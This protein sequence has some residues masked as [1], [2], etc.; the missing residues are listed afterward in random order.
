MNNKTIKNDV[1]RK[2]IIIQNG[3]N[4][5]NIPLKKKMLNPLLF[6]NE[7][8]IK[9]YEE[10][11]NKV[12]SYKELKDLNEVEKNDYINKILREDNQMGAYLEHVKGEVVKEEDAIELAEEKID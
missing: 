1:K 8:Q 2:S 4:I 9:E 11:K 7:A 6:K 5:P 3:F 12:Y 10:S